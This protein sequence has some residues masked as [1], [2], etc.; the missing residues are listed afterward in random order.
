MKA[1][2]YQEK[3]VQLPTVLFLGRRPI[4]F[5]NLKDHQ[6]NTPL[7]NNPDIP[8]PIAD[9][10]L[11]R[12]E[13]KGIKIIVDLY[14]EGIVSSF[15]QLSRKHNLPQH[16]PFKF[17]QIKHWVKANSPKKISWQPKKTPLEKQLLNTFRYLQ[18][19]H[20]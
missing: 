12:W 1:V 8:D 2:E 15:Q 10:T 7:W 17:L 11:K 3:R 6:K 4:S 13:N 18:Y 5:L 9:S 19:S 16:N 20:Q 14:T